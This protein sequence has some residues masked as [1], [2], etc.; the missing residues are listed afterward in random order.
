MKKILLIF[1]LTIFVVL[2]C[3]KEEAF[4]EPNIDQ[5]T[6]IT[7]E[8]TFYKI[9][10]EDDHTAS[11]RNANLYGVFF[12]VSVSGY[13]AIPTAPQYQI[14][15]NKARIDSV[16]MVRFGTASY[17]VQYTAP[18]GTGGYIQPI[19]PMGVYD[20]SLKIKGVWST[21]DRQLSKIVGNVYQY[22]PTGTNLL[23]STNGYDFIKISRLS[24]AGQSYFDWFYGANKTRYQYSIERNGVITNEYL[25]PSTFAGG[26]MFNHVM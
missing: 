12:P 9:V 18:T 13:K 25:N 16:K 20:V 6:V 17:S 15:Y 10:G 24:T 1:I 4:Q 8:E 23:Y 14:A 22:A 21:P 3:N 7:E 2:S 19:I 26:F 5:N 11:T